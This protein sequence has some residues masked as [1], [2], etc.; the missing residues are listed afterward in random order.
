MCCFF[1]L[2]SS[3]RKRADFFDSTQAVERVEKSGVAR[4][5][6]GRLKVTSPQVGIAKSAGILGL[7]KMEAKP[8][9]IGS[10]DALRLAEERDE[11]EQNEIGIDPRLEFEIA[12]EI[13]RGDPALAFLELDRGM[14]RV[15]DFLHEHD[16]R[17]NVS[18][19]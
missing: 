8:P 3:A 12:R 1:A 17:T 10:G 7:E 16:E 19:R 18:I 15:I 6:L 13:F 2:K 11:E 4:C 14:E 9:P 5:Q